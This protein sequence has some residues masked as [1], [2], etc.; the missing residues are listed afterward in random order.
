MPFDH[1]AREDHA[2]NVSVAPRRLSITESSDPLTRDVA[3]KLQ[4]HEPDFAKSVASLNFEVNRNGERYLAHVMP[5]A[6]DVSH[7]DWLILVVAPERDFTDLI[8]I[9]MHEP[10]LLAGLAL[11]ITVPLGLWAASAISRPLFVLNRATQAISEGKFTQTI[12][13]SQIRELRDLDTSFR[14]MAVRLRDAFGDL[15]R[16]NQDLREAE[17]ALSEQNKSLELRVAQRTAELVTVQDHLIDANAELDRLAKLDPLTGIWNRRHFEMR[18]SVEIARAQRQGQPL[19][20][21]MFDIDHFKA[22]NDQYGHPAGD[23]VLVDIC[24]LVQGSLRVTDVFARWG[25]EEFV[26]LMPNCE[27]SEAVRK[28]EA[29]RA[30]VETHVRAGS[31]HIT[32]SFGVAQYR[33]D[34]TAAAWTKRTD[35]ALYTAKSRGRNRVALAG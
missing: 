12:P 24:R 34:E 31:S 10:I 14:K 19:S 35:D 5:S 26:I 25:G 9:R 6:L 13:R 15:Q 33:P 1:R 20:K 32:V 29:L 23:Q 22:V 2:Q 8:G 30:L 18:A 28:A 16:V 4:L 27:A 11:L 17:R 7:P 3:R 21:A